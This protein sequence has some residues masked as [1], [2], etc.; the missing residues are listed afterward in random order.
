MK[1]NRRGVALLLVLIGLAVLSLVTLE[2]RSN[3][4]VELRLAQNQRDEIQAYY[5]AR[6]GLAVS[7]VMMRAQRSVDALPFGNLTNLLGNSGIPKELI[8]SL[9]QNPSQKPLLNVDGGVFTPTGFNLQIWRAMRIDCNL[10]KLFQG[11]RRKEPL[12]DKGQDEFA[13]A[14]FGDMDGCFEVRISDEEERINVARLDAP[15]LTSRVAVAQ[16]LSLFGDKRYTFLYNQEDA[17]K[18]KPTPVDIITSMRDWID[19]DEE[20]SQINPKPEGEPFLRGFGDEN[21]GYAR[22]NPPYR[23][24]N[25][26]FDSLDELYLVYPIGDRIMA[27]F[28]DRLTV[29]PDVNSNLN[30]NT[31]DPM[32]IELAIRAIADPQK[33]DPRLQDPVFID[34]L[35][36]RVRQA[37]WVSVVGL[38]TQDFI[39]V[40]AGAG[41]AVN[42][43][44]VANLRNQRLIGD[45]SSTYRLRIRAQVHDV[46][47]L[48]TTVVRLDD[49]YGTLQSW[50]ED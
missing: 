25:A 13:S 50:R 3:S 40:I 19:D 43:S 29:Y 22:F 33:P 27:A 16:L 1:R 42:P 28:K 5:L 14:R 21:A 32:L 8:G 44:I 4:I 31:D 35:I 11:D 36:Q 12:P 23:A 20:G 45:K 9:L 10:L 6:S 2:T 41:V 15:Q 17:N 37:R 24:K 38:N 7:R 26:R 30:I 34:L 39:S 49:N 46:E 47:K 48:I 18:V